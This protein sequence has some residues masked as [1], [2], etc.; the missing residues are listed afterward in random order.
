MI[1]AFVI[2][3]ELVVGVAALRINLVHTGIWALYAVVATTA[4]LRETL[5]NILASAIAVVGDIA[6]Y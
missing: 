5:S 1:T 2:D 4:M 3:N 6:P